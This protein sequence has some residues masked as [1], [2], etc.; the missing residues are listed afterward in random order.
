[1]F[2]ESYVHLYNYWE[3]PAKATFCG[4]QPMSLNVKP[5]QY[6]VNS[7]IE[8][9]RGDGGNY[10]TIELRRMRSFGAGQGMVFRWPDCT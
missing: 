5:R 1:M 2:R 6:P 8:P 7:P 4:P 10:R 3:L 9:F